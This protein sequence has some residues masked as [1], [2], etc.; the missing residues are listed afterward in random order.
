MLRDKYLVTKDKRYWKELIRILPESWIQ[1]RTVTM[2]YENLYSIVRQRKGHKL[3][4]WERFI[5]WVK[6][7]PYGDD[8]VFLDCIKEN[9]T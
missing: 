2:N 1:R 8:L 3:V 6:T 4:E 5:N 9:E 7:L